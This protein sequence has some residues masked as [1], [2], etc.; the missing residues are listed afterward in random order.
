MLENVFQ[1]YPSNIYNTHQ[2]KNRITEPKE[3]QE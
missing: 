3:E 1:I 2:V